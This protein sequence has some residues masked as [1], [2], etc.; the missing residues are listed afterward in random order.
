MSHEAIRAKLIE[1]LV[2][3]I[4]LQFEISLHY[5]HKNEVLT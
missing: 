1:S 4:L 3:I 5:F 2:L